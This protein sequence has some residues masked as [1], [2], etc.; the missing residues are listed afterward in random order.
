MHKKLALRS[1]HAA[2][3]PKPVKKKPETSSLSDQ[4]SIFDTFTDPALPA[5]S[6]NSTSD[7]PG[8]TTSEHI[9]ELP[10]GDQCPN[11]LGSKEAH[12]PTRNPGPTIKTTTQIRSHACSDSTKTDKPRERQGSPSCSGP[13]QDCA[14]VL[15]VQGARDT[16]R[17]LGDGVHAVDWSRSF[18]FNY[19]PIN[20]GTQS[21]RPPTTHGN[22]TSEQ[23]VMPT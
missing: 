14:R 5:V 2:S 18:T 11:C 23:K 16:L 22:K 12:P 17:N 15:P 4:L 9:K 1:Q 6:Q 3:E 13:L 7:H 10:E 19:N 20:N 8:S 21:V